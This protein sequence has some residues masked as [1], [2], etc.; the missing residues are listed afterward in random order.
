MEQ[1]EEMRLIAVGDD[2]QNIFEFRNSNSKYMEKLILEYKATT[3]ELVENFRSKSNIVDFSNQFVERIKHRLKNNP[4]IPVSHENGRIKLVRY[5]D[6][7]LIT[8]TVNDVLSAELAGTTG[9]LTRTNEEALQITGL[10]L[11]KGVPAKLV[12]SIERFNLY[13]LLEVRYFLD[14]FKLAGDVYIINDDMWADAKMKLKERFG[15]SSNLEICNNLIRDFEAATPMS[16]YKQDL[17]LFVR[18]SK[19][20]DFYGDNGETVMVS[21]IH[22]AKGHEFDN[23]FLM[24]NQ[25]N[26]ETDENLRQLYV[27]MTRAKTN[28]TIHYNG[29][30]LE[31]I[32]TEALIKVF[33]KATYLPPNQLTMQLTHKDVWLN[34]FASRKFLISQLNSGDELIFDG[35]FC[36]NLKGAPVLRFSKLCSNQIDGLR[37][38]NHIPTT[39]KIRFIV[40]WKNKENIENEIM[41]ILPELCFERKN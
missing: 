26:A 20:E 12:Q 32:K 30:F 29:D 16:K 41:I 7:D 10:L 6:C 17:E 19:L 24:L 34:D 31:S 23:V 1:N 4:I 15:G 33:D 14:E 36:R 9:V 2:D 28:L 27:A 5:N 22:K 3:Y 11:K 18:E 8:P 13:D 40:Y 38:R 21:T 37:Q 39:A 25:I 35:E